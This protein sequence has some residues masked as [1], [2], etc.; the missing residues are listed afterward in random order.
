MIPNVDIGNSLSGQFFS[1]QLT[2]INTTLPAPVSLQICLTFCFDSGTHELKDLPIDSS[3]TNRRQSTKENPSRYP[4]TQ[5]KNKTK[6][7]FLLLAIELSFL[8]HAGKDHMTTNDSPADSHFQ[9]HF[10][11]KKCADPA[12]TPDE[13]SPEFYLCGN[14]DRP[15]SGGLA[16][17]INSTPITKTIKP[18]LC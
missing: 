17:V 8:F 15:L 16:D 14:C 6:P 2:V 5:R 1:G 18:Q 10:W 9:A 12:L 7:S 11:R 13:A 4:G 3:A